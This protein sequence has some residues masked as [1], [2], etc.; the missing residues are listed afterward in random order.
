MTKLFQFWN[1]PEAPTE[2]EALLDT[3]KNDAAFDYCRFNSESADS[4]IET[5]F[6]LR[7]LAAFRSCGIP[8]MQADFFRY[9]A[10]FVEGGVYVDADTSNSGRLPELLQGRARGLLMNRETRVANDF[11]YVVKAGD[12][13]YGKVVEQAVVNVEGR[14][15]SNVWE[16]TGPG[17][18]T[19]LHHGPTSASIFDGFDFEPARVVREY[20]LF[21]HDLAYKKGG[22]DW[23]NALKPGSKSI[24]V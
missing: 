6:D 10:L 4:Y 19:K 20:V 18:M 21:Q 2:V 8:A 15:S 17:I 22:G 13:L 5:H 3:W 24:Y 1:L 14:I 11:L 12:P 7:T 23:R 9:C 16:V